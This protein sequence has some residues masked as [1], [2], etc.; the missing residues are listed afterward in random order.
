[1]LVTPLK[2]FIFIHV[3]VDIYSFQFPIRHELF[4]ISIIGWVHN[5][6]FLLHSQD[7]T[8]PESPGDVSKYCSEFTVRLTVLPTAPPTAAHRAYILIIKSSVLIPPSNRATR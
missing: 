2:V 4:W 1:M 3:S 8:Y 7:D 6:V 5:T